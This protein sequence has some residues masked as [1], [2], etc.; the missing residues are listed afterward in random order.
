MPGP[1]PGGIL[2]RSVTGVTA[3][4]AG[5]SGRASDMVPVTDPLREIPHDG[6]SQPATPCPGAARAVSRSPRRSPWSPRSGWSSWVPRRPP[7]PGRPRW[8]RATCRSARAVAPRRARRRAPGEDEGRGHHRRPPG[9]RRPR[10]RGR[11]LAEGALR[12]GDRLEVRTRRDGVWQPWQ[13]ME[14]DDAEHGPDPDSAE[15]RAARPGTAPV[16]VEGDASQ[17]RVVTSR[18]VAPAVDVTFVDP[19]TSAADAAVGASAA[20]RPRRPRRAP[21]STPA[22]TGG[23]TSRCARAPRSTGRCRSGSCTTPS[24]R[25]RTAPPRCPRSSAGSTTST[26]TGAAGTTSATSSSSTGSGASGR[27]VPGEWTRPWRVR[28]PWLQ[29]R[30][31]RRVRHG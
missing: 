11:H 8:P 6:F 17:V 26:S 31:V 10:G 23:P 5:S 19:G 21:P 30:L 16:I 14:V 12:D 13:E 25:T 2:P 9:G 29:L 15:G 22:R 3:G 1:D 20:T 18:A 7:P 28:R 24:A 27:A 4:A